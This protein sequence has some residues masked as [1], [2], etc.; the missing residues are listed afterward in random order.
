MD[1]FDGSGNGVILTPSSHLHGQAGSRIFVC[2]GGWG[3]GGGRGCGR[4]E[5]RARVMNGARE[6]DTKLRDGGHE[7]LDKD[8]SDFFMDHDEFDGSASLPIV[9]KAPQDALG[10]RRV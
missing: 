4:G 1:G 2:G 8:I 10:Y 6:P 7:L 3:G 5:Q 9:R